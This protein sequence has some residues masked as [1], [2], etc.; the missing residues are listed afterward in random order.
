M[1][2][3]FFYTIQVA[4]ND[5]LYLYY[6]LDVEFQHFYT[7]F[8]YILSCNRCAMWGSSSSMSCMTIINL[9]DSKPGEWVQP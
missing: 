8:F 4:Y 2:Q 7:M 3:Y 5:V 1:L 9:G 6:T